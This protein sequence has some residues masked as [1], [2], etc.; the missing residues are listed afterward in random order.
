MST[1]IRYT[2]GGNQCNLGV[3]YKN[4]GPPGS[5]GPPG[6]IGPSGPT[7]PQGIPGSPGGNTGPQGASGPSGPT[8]PQGASGPTGPTG[9]Q[10]ASGPTGPTGPA[11]NLTTTTATAFSTS[12]Q[13]LTANTSAN[14]RHDSTPFAYSITVTTGSPTSFV[15]ANTGIYKIIPS[16]QV[17]GSNNGNIRIWLK[18]N[19]SNITDSGTDTAYKQNDTVVITCE[20]LLSLNSGDSIEVWCQSTTNATIPYLASGGTSPN[21]YP[22]CPGVITNIYRIR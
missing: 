8:G 22:A 7:G 5:T 12:L 21:D 13:S 11:G 3:Q 2:P 1:L 6:P 16:L 4:P 17:L 10:G 15:V 14:V 18:V 19:G 20:Y 9:P